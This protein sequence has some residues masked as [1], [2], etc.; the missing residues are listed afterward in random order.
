MYFVYNFVRI[1]FDLLSL[2]ILV[3]VLLTWFNVD[4][5]HPVV[6]VIHQVTEPILAPIRRALPPVGMLDLSPLVA[7]L[8]LQLVEQ[9]VLS[10]L[11]GIV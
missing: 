2:A 7:L 1:I 6:R 9:I 10:L 8:L 4:P 5:Y 11:R 3:R